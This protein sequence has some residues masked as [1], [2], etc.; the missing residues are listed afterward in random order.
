MLSKPDQ[1]ARHYADLIDRGVLAPGQIFPAIRAIAAEQGVSPD[2]AQKAVRTLAGGGRIE[3]VPGRYI[4][5]RRARENVASPR[6]RARPSAPRTGDAEERTAVM[7]AEIVLPPEYVSDVLGTRPGE[8]VIRREEVAS[9]GSVPVRLTVQWIP[10]PAGQIPAGSL[11]DPHVIPGGVLP[12][13][14]RATGR[15]AVYAQES[16][17]ARGA[18]GRESRMLLVPYGD[19]VIGVV[20]KDCDADGV[21]MYEESVYPCDRVV[22]RTYEL[23]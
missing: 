1:V 7:A 21:L 15:K 14:E 9:V 23:D 2:V 10:S 6:E 5:S 12:F 11:L 20:T 13:V 18:D 16:E 3:K 19:P 17:R 22:S 4:V 8:L